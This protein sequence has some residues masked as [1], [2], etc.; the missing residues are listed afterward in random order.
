MDAPRISVVIPTFRRVAGLQRAVRS[1]FVQTILA[2]EPVTL[3][4]VDN[5]PGG[6]AMAAAHALQAD[7]PSQIGVKVL[8]AP[9][10]GVAN[11][12]N[13]AMEVVKTPLVAF[14]DDDQSAPA[15]WLEALLLTH[16]RAPAAVTFGPVETVLPAGVVRHRA[17]FEAFFARCLEAE[18][19][20]IDTFF[21]CGNCLLDLDRL[22]RLDPM[23]NTAMNE[24]G[25]EDDLL[26]N[27]VEAEGGGF[28]WSPQ[29]PVFEHVPVS[30]AR[31]SY[32]LRRAMAYGQGPCT[33]ARKSDPPR[34]HALL[35]WI[36]VG[37]GQTLVYGAATLAAFAL[38]RPA[39]A[40]WLDRAARGLGKLVWWRDF[41]FYGAAQS[42]PPASQ[43]GASQAG[44]DKTS[45]PRG[46]GSDTAVRSDALGQ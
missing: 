20:P 3:V 6:S 40:V 19:G 34:Y 26:F 43:F 7:A 45:A 9:D 11:A 28:A 36:L 25:G 31:L 41:R 4:I 2:H 23:F 18:E 15:G 17:Y 10:P 33:L 27:A 12:R 14:L 30:R 39:R 8:H 13:A 44:A 29:A 1:V 37:A 42:S 35:F 38:R 16:S 21:G 46:R 32:T 5:D 22:P 24:T